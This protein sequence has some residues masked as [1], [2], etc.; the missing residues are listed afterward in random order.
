MVKPDI[1][2][3]VWSKTNDDESVSVSSPGSE[4]LYGSNKISHYKL[5]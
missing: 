4:H 1:Q 5:L 2:R 3:I